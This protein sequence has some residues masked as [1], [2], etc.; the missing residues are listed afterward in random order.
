MSNKLTK[1]KIDLLIEQ[2]LNEKGPPINVKG[3]GEE[4]YLEDIFQSWWEP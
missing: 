4:D 3:H 1:K 2:V